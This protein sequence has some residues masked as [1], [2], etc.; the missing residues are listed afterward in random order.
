MNIPF[1]QADAFTSVPFKGNM[2]AVCILDDELPETLMQQIAAENNLAETAFVR[3]AGGQFHLRWFTPVVE[4]PLCGHATLA[5]AHIL[6]QEGLAQPGAAIHFETLSGTL[7]AVKEE[8]WITLNFPALTGMPAQLPAEIKEILGVEPLHTIDVFNR[9]LVEVATAAEVVAA[10]PDFGK[11]ARHPK[12]IITA[13][14][15]AGSPYDFVSRFFAP[16]I[17]IDEDPVTGSA[18]CCLA[19][20]WG[21]KLG[22]TE[23]LAYQ[24]SARGGVLKLRL[25]GDRTLLSGQAVTVI[26]GMYTLNI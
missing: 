5:T 20:Y 23:M 19:P 26:K 16:C 3:P 8:D 9:Y 14:G 15:E 17:G 10:A 1:F 12:V 7:S 18:H 4:V 6:W 21:G 2:A 22:K 11:L 25:E 24:A 13:K